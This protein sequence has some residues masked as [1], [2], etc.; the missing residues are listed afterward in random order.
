MFKITYITRSN[1]IATVTHPNHTVCLTVVRALQ[2][3]PT[4][5]PGQD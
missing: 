5:K 1:K 2:A 4:I 3:L